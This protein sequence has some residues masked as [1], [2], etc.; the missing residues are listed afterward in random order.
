M[1]IHLSETGPNFPRFWE[2]RVAETPVI[3]GIDS[4]VACVQQTCV[5]QTTAHLSQGH[6]CPGTSSPAQAPTYVIFLLDQRACPLPC[7]LVSE[8][9]GGIEQ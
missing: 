6:I 2:K 5:G 1:H 3:L 8:Q 4:L 9:C 7:R